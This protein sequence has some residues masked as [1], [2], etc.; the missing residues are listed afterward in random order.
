MERPRLVRP[1][2]TAP[3]ALVVAPQGYGKTTLLAQLARGQARDHGRDVVW[4][5]AE[6]YP[7]GTVQVRVRGP[8][9][10]AA[11]G[12]RP[13]D[14]RDVSDLARAGTRPL[15]VVVDDAHELVG[16]P[17]ETELE[18]LLAS[19]S[20]RVSVAVGSRRALPAIATRGELAARGVVDDV[21]LRLRSWEVERLF[22]EHFRMPLDPDDVAALTWH[23]AGWPVALHLFHRSVRND[24]PGEQR[25]AIRRLD[26]RYRYAWDY[27]A[28]QVLAPLPLEVQRFLHRTAVFEELTESRCDRLDGVD[29][30]RELLLA[31]ARSTSLARR[32][33][34]GAVRVH[35]VLR[36]HLLATVSDEL[37]VA[38][39]R[40]WHAEA[41]AVL[42]AE[43]A[44]DEALAARCRAHDLPGVTRLLT[45]AGLGARGPRARAWSSLIPPELLEGDPRAQ[46][47]RAR[48][49]VLDGRIGEAESWAARAEPRRAEAPDEYAVLRATLDAWGG[50]DGPARSGA[51]GPELD[52][53]GAGLG[54]HACAQVV[55]TALAGNPEAALAGARGLEGGARS[56][57]EGVAQLL[58]GDQ[59]RAG[60][61]LHAAARQVDAGAGAM[62]FAELAAAVLVDRLAPDELHVRLDRIHNEAERRELPWLSRVTHGVVLAF[63]DDPLTRREAS[64]SVDY[65]RR[66]GDPWG[67]VCLSG[68]VALARA[69]YGDDSPADWEAF[70]AESRRLGM[71]SFEAW[72]R[73]GY[74]LSAARAELP[75]AL[76]AAEAAEAVAR[77]AQVPGALA[78]A[79]LALAAAKPAERQELRVL[80]AST[81]AS[82]GLV[83]LAVETAPPEPDAAGEPAEAVETT[84][85]TRVAASEPPVL[86]VRCFGAFS[87][88]VDGRPVDLGPLRPRARR[89]LRLLATRAG[90]AVHRQQLA[91]ALWGDLDTAAAM[92]NLHVN[93][94]AVRRILEPG[95]TRGSERV[96]RRDG[97]TYMLP[98]LPGSECDVAQLEQ[99]LR[100]A[101][102]LAAE[103]DADAMEGWQA[104]LDVYAG[105][106]LPE[107]GD[108]EWVLPLRERYAL[109][110]AGAAA[111]LAT[112]ALRSGQPERAADAA[113]RSIEIDRWG[114][115]PWR[116]L[117]DSLVALGDRAAAGRARG[118][119]HAVLRELGVAPDVTTARA[120]RPLPS[121]RRS[122]VSPGTSRRS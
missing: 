88:S 5:R 91:A 89:T 101:R 78:V 74:A 81:A 39:Y 24:L 112:L 58:A 115:A 28:T 38:R 62:L 16:T 4:V 30:S 53:A 64:R 65:C 14:L 86:R 3:R 26:H 85:P 40:S 63:D 15:L 118:E 54:G 93:V 2:G 50:A 36:G 107:E 99:R 92:H 27:L 44:V 103:R 9:P 117:V 75:D 13:T 21:A 48:E 22:R 10:A 20:D 41:A 49:L 104:V 80:A 11:G 106:L 47:L 55:R 51:S 66:V 46:L 113:R 98:L 84:R 35:R 59:R 60:P 111:S 72:A 67:A 110:A 37:S 31:L 108:A 68:A 100:R 69:R 79:Y 122:R 102:R 1:L 77:A 42:E 96:I 61:S 97:E 116:V 71:G 19:A 17:L 83:G 32:S 120:P 56:L 105:E 7:H 18:H 82:T 70:V 95:A 119:Y 57:A 94:S 23:T 121:P 12:R 90:Q 8:V 45:A 109:E 52:T 6:R 25:Q 76:E 114:D 29:G 34:D 87:V 73:A 43:G 33:D